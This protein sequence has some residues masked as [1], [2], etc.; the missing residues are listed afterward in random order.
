MKD[1]LFN[2]TISGLQWTSIST[3]INILVQILNMIIVSRL[4]GSKEF[5]M[6][7][8]GNSIVDFG[9]FFAT[10]GLGQ[11]LV[12]K[13]N[14]TQIDIRALFTLSL[15]LGTSIFGVLW[16]FMPLFITYLYP[17]SDCKTKF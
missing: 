8:L 1:N 5:G 16:L 2:K 10:M 4:L 13:E 11:A 15:I 6:I 14:L 9:Y 7:T 12:Q 3:V 17:A